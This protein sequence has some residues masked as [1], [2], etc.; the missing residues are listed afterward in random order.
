MYL[1]FCASEVIG[2]GVSKPASVS[3]LIAVAIM[4]PSALVVLDVA[5]NVQDVDDT[6]P[7]IDVGNQPATIVANIEDNA[8]SDA[9]GIVQGLPDVRKVI[10]PRRLY[11]SVPA[12]QR[13]VPLRV[14]LASL[15]NFPAAYDAHN[16]SSHIAK[17]LPITFWAGPNALRQGVGGPYRRTWTRSATNSSLERF[18]LMPRRVILV[19]RGGY[20]PEGVLDCL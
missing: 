8:S 11:D 1:S 7:V 18:T 9:I 20:E 2:F 6:G 14:Q 16:K 17:I 5:E 15:S 3:P 4:F 13:C 19:A 12:S 10:P